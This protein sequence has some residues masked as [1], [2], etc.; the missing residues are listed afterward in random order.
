MILL[1]FRCVLNHI[2]GSFAA[3]VNDK[4]KLLTGMCEDI[5]GDGSG[6][7][8]KDI[9]K[10]ITQLYVGYGETVQCAVLLAR[11][12]IRQLRTVTNEIAKMVYSWRQDK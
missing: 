11:Q 6:R 10:N 8:S 9:C 1:N 3:L 7:F 2:N 12:H 5:F 4:R